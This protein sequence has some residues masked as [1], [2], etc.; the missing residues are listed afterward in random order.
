MKLSDRWPGRVKR[1]LERAGFK[2]TLF[3]PALTVARKD[4]ARLRDVQLLAQR[5]TTAKE[6][7]SKN[8]LYGGRAK[9]FK[10]VDYGGLGE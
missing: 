5:K 8:S 6:I 3:D 1:R 2:V 7:Q 10:I 4:A 9:R